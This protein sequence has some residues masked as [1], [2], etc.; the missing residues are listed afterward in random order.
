MG[1]PRAFVE[2]VVVKKAAEVFWVGGYQGTSIGDLEAGTGIDR[3]SLYHAFGS[4]EALFELAAR[5]YIDQQIGPL[6]S[7]MLE[8]TAGLDQ[9]VAFFARMAERLR[10]DPVKTARGCLIVNALGEPATP[11]RGALAAGAVYRDRF[12]LAFTSALTNAAEWG[13]VN[14][15]RIEDR[16]RVL[17]SMAMGV[18]LSARIDPADAGDLAEAI[19][20]EVS[21]WRNR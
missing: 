13:E 20:A 16:A 18:F 21:G 11:H 3:S 12:R 19:A 9:V 10:A 1:R 2:D 14:R 4:K 8:P 5:C 6:L 7:G 17:T 15:D